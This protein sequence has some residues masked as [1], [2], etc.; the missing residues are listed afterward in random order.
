MYYVTNTLRLGYEKPVVLSEFANIRLFIHGWL[1]GDKIAQHWQAYNK[2][3]CK[4]NR[5]TTGLRMR[6]AASF[7]ASTSK[8]DS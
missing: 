6:L 4:V 3:R 1:A 5:S 2:H 8:N 7:D